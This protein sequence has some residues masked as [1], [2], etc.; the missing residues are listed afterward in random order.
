MTLPAFEI[1][2]M[3]LEAT[4]A[5]AGLRGI[6]QRGSGCKGGAERKAS[7]LRHCSF[8]QNLARRFA[9]GGKMASLCFR[10]MPRQGENGF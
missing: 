9:P 4:L 6:D 7:E 8:L 3:A 1:S 5:G 10:T 2:P